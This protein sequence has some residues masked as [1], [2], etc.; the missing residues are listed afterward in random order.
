MS[1][2]AV[3]RRKPILNILFVEDDVELG[4]LLVR[5][6]ESSG[7]RTWLAK[8]VK[9]ALQL[10]ERIQAQEQCHVIVS[11]FHLPDGTAWDVYYGITRSDRLKHSMIL[12]T[13][14]AEEASNW[15]ERTQCQAFL[16]GRDSVQD[17]QQAARSLALFWLGKPGGD[18]AANVP[19]AADLTEEVFKL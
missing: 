1:G 10:L 14:S 2:A 5:Q 19:Q 8:S 16:K 7:D 6:A 15:R 3:K 11:D 18:A 17:V 4:R 13:A 9:E 12:Y